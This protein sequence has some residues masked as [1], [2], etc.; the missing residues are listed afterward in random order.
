[1]KVLKSN[2]LKEEGGKLSKGSPSFLAGLGSSTFYSAFFSYLGAAFFSYLGAAAF[3][4][5]F[6]LNQA[7]L[8]MKG[9][10]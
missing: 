6:T 7:V 3:F 2:K 9:A 8:H 10:L 4:S 1:M 5:V